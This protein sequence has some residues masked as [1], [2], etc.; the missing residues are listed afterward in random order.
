MRFSSLLAASTLCLAAANARAV[1]KRCTASS[2]STSLPTSTETPVETSTEPPVPTSTESTETPEPTQTGGAP[3]GG[4]NPAHF[5]PVPF[6]KAFTTLPKDQTVPQESDVVRIELSD[7]AL[8]VQK[9]TGG[10]SHDVVPAPGDAPE[11]TLAYQS[12]YPK[13]SYNPSGTPRGGFGFYIGDPEGF[14]FEDASHLLASYAVYFQPG[15]QFNKGGKLPGPYGGSDA[16][17]SFRCSGGR[18][19]DRDKCFD[20][21]LMFRKD[22]MGEV[23]AYLPE[24]DSNDVLL[25]IPGSVKDTTYG[26]SIA[27]GAFTFP[28]GEWTVVAERVKLNTVGSADGEIELFVNGESKIKAEGLVIR[29]HNETTFRGYHF[30]TFFGGST[31][32]WGSPDDQSAWFADVSAAIIE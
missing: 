6:K 2:S 16:D 11:G 23:Y 7:D 18:Q 30:Q 20:L 5:F 9:V 3:S 4:I 1:G 8:A 24:V 32:E 10:T 26:F 19:E 22:G 28:T 12:N 25:D 17:T 27:R 14:K 21:R 29:Q 15:F 31:A 13:G